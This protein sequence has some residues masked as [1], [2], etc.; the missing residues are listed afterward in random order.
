VITQHGIIE[1]GGLQSTARLLLQL[2]QQAL[3]RC[4]VREEL[5]CHC[6]CGVDRDRQRS[7]RMEAA[8]KV[9]VD[10]AVQ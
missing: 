9:A 7:A 3:R 1:Y 10:P 6:R 4:D 5:K 2:I 8:L